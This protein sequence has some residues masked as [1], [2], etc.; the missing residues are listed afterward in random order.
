[1]IVGGWWLISVFSLSAPNTATVNR[2][3]AR[4]E[5]ENAAGN[6]AGAISFSERGLAI[7]PLSWNFYYQRGLAQAALFQ[8][9]PQIEQDFAIARYLMP[10][11]PDIALKEGLVWLSVGDEDLA[12]AVWQE[13]M[14]RWPANAS[15]L[16]GDIFGAVRGDVELR[17]RWRQLGHLNRQCLPILLRNTNR[18]EFEVELNRILADDPELSSLS[19]TERK[20]LFTTWLHEGDQLGLAD[21][22]QRHPDWQTAGWEELATALANAGDYR[23]AYETMHRFVPHPRLPVIEPNNSTKTLLLRFRAT[24]N[25]ATDGL[26]L[27]QSQMSAK[28]FDVALS[29]LKN[30]ST[31]ENVPPAVYFLESEIWAQK[32]DWPKAWQAIVKY[33]G[34]IHHEP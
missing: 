5:L 23:P 2:L 15:V 3:A 34:A 7:A 19:P 22:L 17:D 10:N 11:R 16:Y 9:R 33:Q 21:A 31:A 25:V 32:G 14:Q 29:N 1:M 6:Y 27:V 28:D 4:T 20:I 13:S 26:A 30:F 18:L 24:K 8:P 12:F